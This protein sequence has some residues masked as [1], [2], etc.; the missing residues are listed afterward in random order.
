M[1]AHL[2]EFGTAG[3]EWDG[4][5]EGVRGDG[6]VDGYVEGMC[7][8][9]DLVGAQMG[10]DGAVSEYGGGGEEDEGFIECGRGKGGEGVCQCVER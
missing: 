2:M 4:A 6:D 9:G 8:Q 1:H 7:Y 5:N 10:D 3:A